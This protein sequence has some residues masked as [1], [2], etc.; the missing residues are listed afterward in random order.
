MLTIEVYGFILYR[1]YPFLTVTCIYWTH[2]QYCWFSI[3]WTI[4]FQT[5]LQIYMMILSICRCYPKQ[6][7][8]IYDYVQVLYTS[9]NPISVF[10]YWLKSTFV[11][12]SSKHSA[13][14]KLWRVCVPSMM[15]VMSYV[16]VFISRM[17]LYL[18]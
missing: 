7:V 18:Q 9:N 6:S 3:Q 10:F 4:F 12:Y 11:W 13:I 8:S 1:L 2:P 17:Y 16:V 14:L 15:F 5:Y